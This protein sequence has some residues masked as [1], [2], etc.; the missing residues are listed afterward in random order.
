MKKII[1]TILFIYSPINYS[2]IG[3]TYYCIVK[4]SAWLNKD[5]VL[6]SPIGVKNQRFTLYWFQEMAKIVKHGEADF[7]IEDKIKIVKQ[8]EFEFF[9]NGNKTLANFDS[10]TGRIFLSIQRS[11]NITSLM[12]NCKKNK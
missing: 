9:A 10:S 8:N 12:E 6:S 7:I 1:F 3:E 4:H 5:T 2:G 11:D